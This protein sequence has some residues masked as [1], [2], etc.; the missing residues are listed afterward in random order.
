MSFLSRRPEPQPEPVAAPAPAP[1][2]APKPVIDTAEEQRKKLVKR[3]GSRSPGTVLSG[4]Q[5]FL[6]ATGGKTLL[7]A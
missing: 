3:K 6:G 4:D 7:G 1:T 2:P 5:E